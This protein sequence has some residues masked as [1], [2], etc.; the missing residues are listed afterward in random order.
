MNCFDGVEKERIRKFLKSNGIDMK[1]LSDIRSC[2]LTC[3]THNAGHVSK[4]DLVS[5]LVHKNFHY[6]EEFF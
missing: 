6:P 3:D 2:F 4:S 1:N 5:R